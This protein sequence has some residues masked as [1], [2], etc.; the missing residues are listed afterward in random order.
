MWPLFR[1]T[2]MDQTLISVYGD[3][4]KCQEAAEEFNELNKDDPHSDKYWAGE[5]IPFE[6][7]ATN[8]WVVN[9]EGIKKL[10]A[11]QEGCYEGETL[12]DIVDQLVRLIKVIS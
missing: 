3:K 5:I 2:G 7:K 4:G 1:G 9:D 11:W 12:S 10:S 8:Y 6:L